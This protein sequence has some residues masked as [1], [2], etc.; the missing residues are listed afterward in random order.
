MTPDDLTMQIAQR[1]ARQGGARTSFED[2]SLVVESLASLGYTFEPPGVPGRYHETDE[3]QHS[4]ALYL[5]R[6][7]G[8]HIRAVYC[9]LNTIDKLGLR[10]REP[11]S[12]PSG[13]RTTEPAFANVLQSGAHRA[14]A[15]KPIDQRMPGQGKNYV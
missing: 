11:A 15:Q 8:L 7:T 10:I 4:M 9:V 12:H 5:S 13:L 14:A 3:A 2:A 6:K 1:E